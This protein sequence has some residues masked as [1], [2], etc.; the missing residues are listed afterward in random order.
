MAKGAVKRAQ[1]PL[2]RGSG[3]DKP[4][5]RSTIVVSLVSL[6]GALLALGVSQ[7]AAELSRAADDR[8]FSNA[9]VNNLGLGEGFDLG[10]DAEKDAYD[11][12]DAFALGN[13]EYSSGR[14]VAAKSR[15]QEAVRLSPTH[16]FAWANLGNVQV[17]A[18]DLGKPAFLHHNRS[19]IP[20]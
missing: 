10:A 16:S 20:F 8:S 12:A 7:L 2:L 9:P 18:R 17:R 3:L 14:L 1:A 19:I 15:Y 13:T 5:H 4:W 11:A 6:V